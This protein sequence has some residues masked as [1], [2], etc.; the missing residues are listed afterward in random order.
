M[1]RGYVNDSLSA[2]DVRDHLTEIFDDTGY[3]V[4]GNSMAEMELLAEMLGK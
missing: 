4:P 2:E 3:Q 1:T